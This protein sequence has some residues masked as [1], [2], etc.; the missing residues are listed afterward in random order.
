MQNEVLQKLKNH[1]SFRER[2][3]RS[4]YLSILALRNLNLEAKYKDKT[5]TLEE[6]AEFATTYGSYERVWRKCLQENKDLRGTDWED[7][8]VLA[9]ETMLKLN[10]ETDYFN[11]IAK[12][13]TL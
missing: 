9:E 4:K 3:F 8:K 2:R 6:L 7:G 12:L 13:K 1:E 11:N 10:Y 5:L